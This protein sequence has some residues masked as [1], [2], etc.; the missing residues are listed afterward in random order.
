MKAAMVARKGSRFMAAPEVSTTASGRRK[1]M[2][3]ERQE[4]SGGQYYAI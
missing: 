4:V 2:H 3:W 1:A